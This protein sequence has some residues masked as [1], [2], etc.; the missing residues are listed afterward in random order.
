MEFL[1]GG[2]SVPTPK[3]R[4]ARVVVWLGSGRLMGL[5]AKVMEASLVPEA[6]IGRKIKYPQ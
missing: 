5:V 1:A 6:K 4:A 3:A 2:C